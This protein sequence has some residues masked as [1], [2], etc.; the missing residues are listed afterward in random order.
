MW[1]NVKVKWGEFNVKW[2]R[3]NIQTV[4]YSQSNVYG[5]KN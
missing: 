2:G 4:V 3:V 5:I 1:G